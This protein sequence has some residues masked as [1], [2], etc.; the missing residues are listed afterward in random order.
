MPPGTPSQAEAG[1]STL[2]GQGLRGSGADG[3]A[4]GAPTGAAAGAAGAEGSEQGPGQELDFTE[5]A[6]TACAPH[7][8]MAARSAGARAL[9]GVIDDV[10]AAVVEVRLG[11]PRGVAGAAEGA[12]AAAEH[13]ASVPALAYVVEGAQP[14]GSLVEAALCPSSGFAACFGVATC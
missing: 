6:R 9:L 12:P 2:T 11:G 8:L 3:A 7:R 5:V 4:A 1:G 10:D 13:I 14:G